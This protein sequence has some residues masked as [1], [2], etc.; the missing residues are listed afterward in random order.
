MGQKSVRLLFPTNS[1]NGIKILRIAD[2]GVV[3]L[4]Q[5]YFDLK[6]QSATTP[7]WRKKTTKRNLKS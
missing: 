7:H 6:W 5:D 3:E 2:S 4:A 1:L